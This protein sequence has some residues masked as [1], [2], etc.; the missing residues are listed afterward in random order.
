MQAFGKSLPPFNPK[1]D[2]N[3]TIHDLNNVPLVTGT[4][5]VKWHIPSYA[6]SA[7]HRGHTPRV[8]IRDH[9]VTWDYTKTIGVRLTLDKHGSLQDSE[10]H[11]E[12]LQEYSP[13]GRGEKIVLGNVR[14]NLAE[15]CL[16]EGE[17]GG[18][19]FNEQGQGEGAGAGGEEATRP[20]AGVVRRYLMRESKINSTLKIGI[21]MHQTEGLTT[22]I[23]PPLKSGGAFT[24]IAGI[25][26]G[27]TNPSH[28]SATDDDGHMPSMSRGAQESGKLQ[29]MYRQNLAATWAAQAGELPPDKCIEDIFRG[30][31]GWGDVNA[32]PG[33]D[34]HTSD[35]AGGRYV[36]GH[37]RGLSGEVGSDDEKGT[38]RGHRR[39]GSSGTV[40]AGRGAER[41][42][43]AVSIISN[44]S[45]G[46]GSN[47]PS[48][49]VS[50]RTSIQQ[51]VQGASVAEKRM[52]SLRANE[53]D[54][55][56]ERENLRSWVIGGQS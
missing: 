21:H 55:F 15:Y 28:D 18:Q 56:A 23:P 25:I 22:F 47:T 51:Q 48:V 36:G 20:G 24:G 35:G 2:L 49:G 40:K 41:K 33:G 5:Y 6:A 14:L 43:S 45:G 3:L 29:D 46:S 53:V 52:R 26:A 10:I 44:R 19:D 1:F 31:D 34:L 50:G 38:V 9:K 7:E 16:P 37:T 54:E 27:S 8:L 17:Y 32:G 4:S 42:G 30:G 12:V 11:F 13:S 39:H